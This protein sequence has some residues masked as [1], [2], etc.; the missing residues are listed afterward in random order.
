MNRAPAPLDLETIEAALSQFSVV[1]V[2]GGTR[3]FEE[4]RVRSLK[5]ARPN[6]YEAEVYEKKAGKSYQV[7]L[8]FGK[9]ASNL[10]C[11]CQIGS[12]C[13]H[14]Y[15]ALLFL[16]K[17]FR[18]QA[19][20]LNKESK[21]APK[22]SDYFSLVADPTLLTEKLT[23]FVERLEEL[24]QT[25]NSGNQINGRILKGL[26]SDWP[27][28]E[29]W[30]EIKIASGE[31]LS[32][33]QF[34]HFLV[35]N[36]QQR[37]LKIPSLFGELNDISVSKDLIEK[38]NHSREAQKWLIRFERN[39]EPG[40]YQRLGSEFRW[41]VAGGYLCLEVKD[42]NDVPFRPVRPDELHLLATEWR[43]GRSQISS[44]SLLLLLQHFLADAYQPPVRLPLTPGLAGRL[45]GLFQSAE[46][47]QR[48]VGPDGQS[49]HL[50]SGGAGWE[51][52]EA[53]DFVYRFQL[54]YKGEVP[55]ARLLMLPGPTT[56]YWFGSTLL[57][58][59]PPPFPMDSLECDPMMEIPRSAVESVPGIRYLLDT[60][61]NLP[62]SLSKRVIRI[63]PKRVLRV[64]T[65]PTE[66]GESVVFDTQLVD[67][68]H[69]KEIQSSGHSGWSLSG[70]RVVQ[71]GDHFSVYQLED[72]M[73]YNQLFGRLPSEFDPGSKSWRVK[74]PKRA[75][76]LFA[77]WSQTLPED[78][79]LQIPESL[80]GLRA[81]PLEIDFSFDC[82]DA[83]NDWFD[84]RFSWSEADLALSP[85]ELQALLDARGNLVQFSARAY[86][87]L[88]IRQPQKLIKTLSEL[89]I[90]PRDL[91][92]GP[93]R[94]HLLQLRSLLTANLV[95]KELQQELE[96][97]LA[98][99]KTEVAC[100][101][102]DAIRATL[103][104]YQI[105]GFHFLVYLSLNRFGGI[106]ADDMGLGKTIQTLTW[107]AW[108]RHTAA[109][110]GPSLI[111]C[112]KSVVD[113][114]LGEADR[115][116][117]TLPIAALKRPELHPKLIE[118]GR[119]LVLNYAQLRILSEH[120]AQ[121]EWDAVIF[122]EGQYLKN[123]NSQTAQSARALKAA[124]K[125]LLT[126]TPI[127]NKLLDLW[128]LMSCVMPG[129]LGTQSSFKR[130]FQDSGDA[131]SRLRLSRRARPFLLRRTKEEV[132]LELPPKIEEDIRVTIEGKQEELYQAEI[133]VARQHLLKIQNGGQLDQERFNL[134]TSLLRLRQICCHP[135]LAGL[136]DVSAA[137]AKLE[138]LVDLLEPIIEEGNKVL[139]FS[140]FVEMLRLIEERISNLGCPLFKLTGET[141]NRG[142]LI[143]DFRSTQGAAV[144]LISLKA[145]GSGLNLEAASYV[146]LFD[147]WWNPAVENQ[148]ID[149][150][151]RIGQTKTVFAYRLLVRD[152]IED[153]IRQ[154]QIRK[155]NLANDVLGEEAFGRALTLEDFRYLL[156]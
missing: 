122:D 80:K 37:G 98:E 22:V 146:I 112:P 141:E 73:A 15:A 4:G 47:R 21:N 105:A 14:V 118:P 69:G 31:P 44:E 134:L 131:E 38:W 59:G 45:N 151:H 123:S 137:S 97:R 91:A 142:D 66:L 48:T 71:D 12:E 133:K 148:A 20:V 106:L 60:I 155:S 58:A 115:Y 41:A 13:K 62:E 84:L 78:V 135:A 35:A 33:V 94:L 28:E 6:T 67:P 132:A 2:N 99:I 64:R 87:S 139:V 18:K 111:V 82:H 9:S 136:K 42:G 7:T 16:S 126:G 3:L 85:E 63:Q 114:W 40:V 1:V 102:P 52:V 117:P 61:P 147:P 75:V 55:D 92:A 107:V 81:K 120:L 25:Y 8:S 76:D 138:A 17:R 144:F 53:S 65:E 77:K 108:L 36:L 23:D 50:E 143:T 11:T 113:N 34:W 39:N 109:I 100:A 93:Q 32:R 95:P 153:K 103:R 19:L 54:R 140:Q 121:I 26:F 70:K 83:G 57:E 101:I 30:S 79:E 119:V 104:P 68:N 89:G 154:L 5:N 124:H 88:L 127:E 86:R 150:T 145:G 27:A 43:S 72:Q 56:L 46:V 152:T 125:I 130:E 156:E 116:F 49:L 24:F 29:H 96:R 51:M 129:A 128:S 110:T 10:L 90:S 74:N 149:R